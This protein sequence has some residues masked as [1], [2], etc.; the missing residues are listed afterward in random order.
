[1]GT[2]PKSTAL[3]KN[4][5]LFSKQQDEHGHFYIQK[6]TGLSQIVESFCISIVQYTAEIMEE[7]Y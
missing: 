3:V 4:F 6:N 1:V 5:W 7:T 2:N